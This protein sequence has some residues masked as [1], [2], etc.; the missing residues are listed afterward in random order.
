M[1][2]TVENKLNGGSKDCPLGIRFCNEG[3]LFL[4]FMQDRIHTRALKFSTS[5]ERNFTVLPIFRHATVELLT[6]LLFRQKA[7]V[8]QQRKAASQP[9]IL[10]C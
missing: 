5:N 8:A 9:L 1:D 10:S 2:Q 7:C 4:V 3:L 6:L